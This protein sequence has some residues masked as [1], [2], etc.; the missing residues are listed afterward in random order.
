[1]WDVVFAEASRDH[2]STVMDV[3]QFWTRYLIGFKTDIGE[4]RE[5]V[6]DFRSEASPEERDQMVDEFMLDALWV[7]DLE[8]DKYVGR[9]DFI[10]K[11]LAR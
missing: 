11:H 7:Y 2:P 8:R 5:F 1:M 4:Y 6:N 3:S 10:N 9:R